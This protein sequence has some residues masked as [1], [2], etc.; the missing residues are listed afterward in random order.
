[1]AGTTVRPHPTH[2]RALRASAT[3]RND[4]RWP[5]PWPQ[6]VLMLSD[7]DGRVVGARS[8]AP[9]DYLGGAPATPMLSPGQTA[10]IA[11]DIHEPAVETVS[12]AWELH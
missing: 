11:L 9:K 12:Y 1:M 7:L 10:D 3:F 5:Q 2:P 4:A 8:F 6:V